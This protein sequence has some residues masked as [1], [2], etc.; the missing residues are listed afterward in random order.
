MF[1]EGLYPAIVKDNDDPLMSGRVQIYVDHLHSKVPTFDLPWAYPFGGTIGGSFQSIQSCI[2]EKDS[3]V[4]VFFEKPKIFENP[5]YISSVVFEASA[6]AHK[7]YST[8]IK[9][10]AMTDSDYPDMKFTMLKNLLNWG[11]SSAQSTPEAYINHPKGTT[12][13]I[14]KDGNVDVKMIATGKVKV[15]TLSGDID[16]KSVSG[17]ITAKTTSGDVEIETLS[18]KIKTSGTWEHT[19]NMAILTGKL[20][21]DLDVTWLNASTP[22]KGSTH[23]H[24]T[25]IPGPPSSPTPGT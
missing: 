2:P 4:W 13:K 3:S 1:N 18:G 25:A 19:G 22:T 6:E 9:T 16:L 21:V 12:V 15:E 24:P 10:L 14:D 17:N 8:M 23:Q 11:M 20:D 5:F 7:M